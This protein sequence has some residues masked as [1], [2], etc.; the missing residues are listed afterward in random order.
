MQSINR[1][2]ETNPQKKRAP[3]TLPSWKPFC[4]FSTNRIAFPRIFVKCLWRRFGER[5]SF[6]Y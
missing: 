5:I 2:R 1:N 3:S 6:A 4:L